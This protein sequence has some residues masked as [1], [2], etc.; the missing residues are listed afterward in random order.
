MNTKILFVI[1]LY[2]CP[3]KR[4]TTYVS[5]VSKYPDQSIFIYDNS[6]YTQLISREKSIYVHDAKNSGLSIAYNAACKYAK[7]NGF[8]WLL[9][10]DQD[11]DFSDITVEDYINAIVANPE[12]KLFAPKV[13]CGGKY[14]SPAKVWHKMAV[15]RNEV[16]SGIVAL[17]DYSPINSGICVNVDAM[18]ECGGYNESVFLDYSDFEFINRFKKVYPTVFIINKEIKQNFSVV[19]DDKA[20]TIRRYQL[21]C[22]SIKACEKQNITDSFWYFILVLKRCLSI[23]LRFKTW[24]PFKIILSNYLR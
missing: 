5:L 24:V 3:V 7:K 12:I 15:V 23:S 21:F 18:L 22:K 4:T 6:P 17:S 16:P 10:L 14:M 2:K 8:E 1:V 19:T 13:K 9:L 20:S 11:T